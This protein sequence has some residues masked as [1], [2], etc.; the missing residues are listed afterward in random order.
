[1]PRRIEKDATD[2][3]MVT[4]T[5]YTQIRFENYFANECH[6]CTKTRSYFKNGKSEIP[7]NHARAS[8]RLLNA[9]DKYIPEK[10]VYAWHNLLSQPGFKRTRLFAAYQNIVICG[11]FQV[12]FK[13][14]VGVTEYLFNCRY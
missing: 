3:R 14:A 12:D 9:D 4:N 8:F 2:T 6:Q 1:M 10:L 11:V 7:Q 5:Y 13:A